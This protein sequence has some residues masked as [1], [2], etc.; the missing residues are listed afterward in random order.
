MPA[1][2]SRTRIRTRSRAESAPAPRR[3]PLGSL[4]VFVAVAQ[5]LNFSRAADALGVTTSAASV[6]VRALEE[7][8]NQPL[9]RRNGREVRLTI[10]GEALLPRVQEALRQLEH[11]IDDVRRDRGGGRLKIT[12]FS[13]FMHAWLVPRMP[14]FHAAHPDIDI[15]L[16]SSDATVDFVRDDFHMAVRLGRGD[17]PNVRSEKLLDE[18]LIPV[19]SP[20]LLAK[21]GPLRR[22]E[23]LRR[24]PLLHSNSE[25]W[26]CWLLDG[27]AAGS[28]GLR[29]TLVDDSRAIVRMAAQGAGLALVRW[30]LVADELASGKLVR[31]AERVLPS[32]KSYWLVYPGRSRD[33]PSVQAFM[34]W[35]R[36]EAAGFAAPV[37]VE[38][39]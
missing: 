13:S 21:H 25:P 20:Q 16:D 18:W 10:E 9:F 30:S 2:V 23:D 17:W 4:R 28:A 39:G 7:Y 31:A 22:A 24:Y 19:C 32:E 29:G 35:I 34:A 12:T 8:L 15:H 38:R 5:H 27:A 37:S 33:L 1:K 3:L 11:A 14:R 26:T 36:E 6:Q